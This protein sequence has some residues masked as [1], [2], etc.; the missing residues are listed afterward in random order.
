M[1][2]ETVRQIAQAL[3][4]AEETTNYGAPAFKLQGKLLTCIPTNKAAEPNSLAVAIDPDQR[5]ALLAEAPE[6]YYLPS[7][8]ESSAIVLVRLSQINADQLRDLLHTAHR[9]VSS[10]QKRKRTK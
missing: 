6:T 8:Y 5:A 9:F 4:N 3:P 2:F 10:Q 1:T 7:H